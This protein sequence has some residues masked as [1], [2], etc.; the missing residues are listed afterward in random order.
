[1][2][3][4][5]HLSAARVLEVIGTMAAQINHLIILARD[6]WKSARFL[7][8]IL[9]LEAGP[10][11]A[12]FVPVRTSNGTTLDFAESPDVRPGHYAFLMGDS[13]FDGALR[14][15]R[16]AGVEYYAGFDLAGRGEINHL[17]GGRGVYFHD[18]SG[19]LLEIITHPYGPV[20][21]RWKSQA[22]PA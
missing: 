16:E 2:R 11:W 10:Q 4:S 15:I 5:G 8:G 17:Y 9:G 1:M 12:H 20:P 22:Q 3:S 21:E 7:A 6:K 18:P 13:E 14:R 19:H